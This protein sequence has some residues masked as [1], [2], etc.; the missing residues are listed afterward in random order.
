MEIKIYK[1]A[2]LKQGAFL[3]VKH[4]LHKGDNYLSIKWFEK[5]LTDKFNLTVLKLL[6]IYI[7][8]DDTDIPMGCGVVFPWTYTRTVDKRL[9]SVFVLPKFRNKGVG[10][11]LLNKMQTQDYPF[12]TKLLY[13]TDNRVGKLFYHKHSVMPLRP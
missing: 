13:H 2:R 11:L 6:T 3:C 4:K 8:F 9:I 12:R 5:I 7:A 1:G 10:A